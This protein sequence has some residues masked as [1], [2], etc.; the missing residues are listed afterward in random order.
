MYVQI[1]GTVVHIIFC[2]IF[3]NKMNLDIIGIG[4]AGTLSN[5]FLLIGNLYMT[6]TIEE[7]QPALKVTMRDSRIYSQLKVYWK[8]GFPSMVVI[9][10]EWVAYELITLM[11]G[12]LS[13]AELSA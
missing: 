13:V 11:A 1:F 9:C 4:I 7:I 8:L 3:V 5:L 10:V 2:H 12:Y 6:S